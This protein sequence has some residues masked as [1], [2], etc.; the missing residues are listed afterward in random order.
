MLYLRHDL[1]DSEA[2]DPP[3][4]MRSPLKRTELW[5]DRPPGLNGPNP[6]QL[7]HELLET[8]YFS[9]LERY[10]LDVLLPPKT[11]KKLLDDTKTPL[12]RPFGVD[13][14]GKEPHSLPNMSLFRDSQEAR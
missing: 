3:I 10:V 12:A 11:K 8:L 7:I 5:L 13:I 9:Q 14:E 2:F 6:V 1:R 4:I